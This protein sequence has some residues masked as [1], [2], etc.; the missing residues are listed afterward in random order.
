H[1]HLPQSRQ[2]SMLIERGAQLRIL[3]AAAGRATAGQGGI[4]LVSGEAGIGKTSMLREFAGALGSDWRV[5]WGGCE[6][7]YTPRPLAPLQDL[8]A[9]LGSRVARLLDQMAA[10][11]RL[12]PAVLENL[13]TAETAT[14]LVFED[15]HWAD[16]G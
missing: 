14:L 9:A 11:A 1:P 8:A 3:H 4:V 15:V 7:L 12:F 16:H 2:A 5:L 6:A 10:P 13:Q